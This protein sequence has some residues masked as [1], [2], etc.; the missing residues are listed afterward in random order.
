MTKIKY[1]NSERYYKNVLLI[2]ILLAIIWIAL[3]DTK[4][5]SDF[6]YYYRLS[7]DIANGGSFGDT[8]TSVGYCIVLGGIFK[9]F[10]ASILK[11]KIFNILLTFI[12]CIC[13]FHIL[14]I[15]DIKE[16]ARK[17][18][19][20]LFVFTPNN[21]FYNS[22]LAT[23]ILFTTILLIITLIYFTKL[24]H[25]YIL[26]GILCGLNTMIKPFFIIFFFAIFLV[27]FIINKKLFKALK[28]ALIVLFF[29]VLLISPWVYRNTKLMGQFTSVSNN[30]GIVLYINNNSQNK[31]GR[32]MPAEN[33][34]NSIVK[35]KEYKNANATQKNIM[36]KR[37]AKTWI[38]GHPLQFIELGFKRLFNNYFWDDDI[39]YAIYGAQMNKYIIGL[40]ALITNVVR[41]VV[42]IPA[43][44]YILVR[45]TKILKTV[46]K[47]TKG[48]KLDKF[49]L[50]NIILF[51]MFTIV[52]F[53]TEGQSRYAFPEIFIMTYCFQK[54]IE[55]YTRDRLTTKPKF[56]S[57]M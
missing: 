51:Y 56:H 36:L 37:A 17:V 38:K 26:I 30:E 2:G 57:Y 6:D 41:I 35:T 4:P 8:Y 23:E 11:A 19:F 16:K 50:Y 31:L 5:Y 39:L 47:K 42:F 54:F 45:S 25:K 10:G 13:F 34:E 1:L 21:I 46:I 33:V 14:K 44:I 40:F 7:V 49:E 55:L 52:Y 48:Y 3:V 32:W 12:S 27:E 29:T 43:I 15:A 53:I 22:I 20:T 28:S 24:K 9:I 18:I